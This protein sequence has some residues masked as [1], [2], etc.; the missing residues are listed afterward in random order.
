M[1]CIRL[2]LF[3]LVASVAVAAH[4][5]EP[6]IGDIFA[7]DPGQTF[8]GWELSTSALGSQDQPY[9]VFRRKGVDQDIVALVAPLARTERGGIAVEK[10]I[11]L[12]KVTKDAGEERLDGSN[13]AFLN[14]DPA[15]AFFN[16]R[17]RIARGYFVVKDDILL[18]RWIVDDPDLC[19]YEGG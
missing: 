17:T 2:L 10:I 15:V 5:E 6:S 1:N 11:K 16:R 19:A 8:R 13:C 4:G 18:R 12:V 14:L 9:A 7:I 3:L